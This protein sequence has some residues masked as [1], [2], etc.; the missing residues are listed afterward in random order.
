[1]EINLSNTNWSSD[2]YDTGEVLNF[3]KIN[4]V[5]VPYR[6]SYFYEKYGPAVRDLQIIETLSRLDCVSQ[7]VVINRP[8]SIVENFLLKKIIRKE[9]KLEKV[10]TINSFSW[11]VF[12][13]SRGRSWISKCYDEVVYNCLEK[14]GKKD[15]LNVFL[16]FLPMGRFLKVPQE[17]VYW[18]DLIDNFKKHNR[19]SDSEKDLVAKKYHSVAENAGF[20]T[21]VS[22]GCFNGEFS[23]F[24]NKKVLSNKIFIPR[25][26]GLES[27]RNLD[28]D[29]FMYDFGF[30]GFVTDK[31]DIEFVERLSK[32]YTIVIYGDF[33]D[34][35]Y[36]RKLKNNKNIYL[37][38]RFSYLELEGICKS[39]RVGLLPYLPEKSHD[40][41]PLKVYEYI[42]YNKPCLSSLDYEFSHFEFFVNYNKTNNLYDCI[43]NLFAMSDNE[44]ISSS[45]SEDAFLD[46]AINDLLTDI[47]KV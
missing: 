5:V 44:S 35:R 28:N 42:K 36:E 32:Y 39:F 20:L 23:E 4:I 27:K 29:A 43:E 30:I 8:V 45:I 37:K 21:A 14:Y 24:Y 1:M 6:D 46:N 34:K 47:C 22:E 40:E 9:L 13:V 7:I 2:E 16:D 15:C 38:G 31:F 33:F 26:R 25:N 18:Y 12:G 10:T 17:W 41:S 19:Y 3:S 11:D